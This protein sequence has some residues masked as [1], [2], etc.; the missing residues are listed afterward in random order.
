MLA[1]T[2]YH[3]FS[4][5]QPS[6]LKVYGRA[7]QQGNHALPYDDKINE[8]WLLQQCPIKDILTISVPFLFMLYLS[9]IIVCS[10]CPVFTSCLLFN[11]AQR[12]KV[13]DCRIIA[14]RGKGKY[15][16]T[17]NTKI[18]IQRRYSCRKIEI[19]GWKAQINK[20][21][22]NWY[23]STITDVFLIQKRVNV[24]EHTIKMASLLC[25][26]KGRVRAMQ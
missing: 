23:V 19:S 20:P 6:T 3:C 16:S 11:Y 24:G 9:F 22:L 18:G 26:Q 8:P 1:Y 7:I 21:K 17:D 13:F 2:T 15:R 25:V 14:S 10:Q 12:K 5:S 4:A